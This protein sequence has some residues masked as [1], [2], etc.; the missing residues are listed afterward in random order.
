MENLSD[1]FNLENEKVFDSSAYDPELV[2]LVQN[3]MMQQTQ[4]VRWNDIA[5]LDNVKDLL[6]E[7]IVLPMEYPDLFKVSF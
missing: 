2:S 7:A 6:A 1:N 5:G 3:G 4:S